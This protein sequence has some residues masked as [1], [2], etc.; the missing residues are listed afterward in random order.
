MAAYVA[1]RPDIS[2]VF[3]ES[4]GAGSGSRL[5]TEAATAAAKIFIAAT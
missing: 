4:H 3:F 5:G 1:R 2:F